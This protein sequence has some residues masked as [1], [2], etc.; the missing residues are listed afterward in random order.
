MHMCRTNRVGEQL[1]TAKTDSHC[2]N[3]SNEAT[4]GQSMATTHNIGALIIRIGFWGP[5]YDEYYKEPTK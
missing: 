2:E 3:S 4:T 1:A 5:L